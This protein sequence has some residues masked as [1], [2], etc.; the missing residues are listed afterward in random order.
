[1]HVEL[2]GDTQVVFIIGDPIAQ[3][4]SPALLTRRLADLRANTVVVPGHVSGE[5]IPAFMAGLETVR[6]APGLVITVPHKQAMLDYCAQITDRARFAGS[7]NVMHRG[8]KGWVGDNTDGMG[9]VSGLR[10]AGGHVDDD[11]RR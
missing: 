2:N 5:A 7:A 10:A 6:N 3:V 8:P 1:M 4:K 9:Y 11:L